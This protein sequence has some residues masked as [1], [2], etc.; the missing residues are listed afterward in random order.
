MGVKDG[1]SFFYQNK[2]YT[3]TLK[4]CRQSVASTFPITGPPPKVGIDGNYLAMRYLTRKEAYQDFHQL[5][6]IPVKSVAKDIVVLCKALQVEKFEPILFFDG[7]TNPLKDSSEGKARKEV[8]S[9]SQGK[10]QKIWEDPSNKGPDDKA[11]LKLLPDTVYF[12]E[13]VFF[14]V[15]EMAQTKKI[16]A[17]GSQL[18]PTLNSWPLVIRTLLTLQ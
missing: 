13:D 14:E 1:S 6:K 8:L 17:V 3:H 10:L 7:A 4:Q 12:Q 15:M 16:Q 5:E 2:T 9:E 11:Y 18:R